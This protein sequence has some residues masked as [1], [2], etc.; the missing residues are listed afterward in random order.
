M[1]PARKRAWCSTRPGSSTARPTPKVEQPA[2]L[3]AV[4]RI[5]GTT[6]GWGVPRT[7]FS[8]G[9][10]V[11]LDET[12]TIVGRP[13]CQIT[14]RRL[15]GDNG[16]T[17]DRPLPDSVVLNNP[18][19]RYGITNVV[20]CT[21]RLT[22]VKQV[23]NGSADPS[24]W[25]SPGHGSH[26]CSPGPQGTTGTAAATADVTA[27][28]TYRLDES[29]GPPTYIQSGQ[30]ERRADSRV[31]S[32]LG[33]RGGRRGRHDVIPGFS[34]GL[35]GG[36]TVP[37]GNWVRCTAVNETATLSCARS[38]TTPTAVQPS[39]ATSVLTATPTGPDVPAGLEP[40]TVT[41]SR[42]TNPSTSARTSNTSSPKPGPPGTKRSNRD[43]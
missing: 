14:S 7:G 11:E 28:V 12:A 2:G 25:N 5:D 16:T 21:Q 1:H 31:H 9:D 43:L 38:S 20:T 29:G 33:L 42:S 3:E 13:F 15:T 8:Q 10:T 24:V 23:A 35:N 26:G 32:E 22:L 41:G 37:R 4:G 34:D 19:N 27:D 6:Q 39:P 17:V 40:I 18:T 30:P 36:V